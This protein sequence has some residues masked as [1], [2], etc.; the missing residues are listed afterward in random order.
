VAAIAVRAIAVAP[1]CGAQEHNGPQKLNLQIANLLPI[2]GVM[3]QFGKPGR[4]ASDVALEEIRKAAAKAG[5]QHTVT[6]RNIDY[7][8]DPPLAVKY[9]GKLQEKGTDCLTGPWGSGQAGRVGAAVAAPKRILQISPSAGDVRLG[10][11]QDR[12]YLNSVAPPDSLQATAL[13]ELMSR[14]LG[15]AKGKRVNVGAIDLPYGKA[16]AKAFKEQWTDHKGII[17]KLVTY[18]ADQTSF[19][20]QI[21]ALAQGKPDAWVFFDFVDVY[22]R[23]ALELLQDKKSGFK[24]SK[25]FGTDSLANPRL[26][27]IGPTVSDGL[28]GVAISAPNK[29]RSA[30][31]FD[32]AFKRVP[33]TNR[34]T[35][36]A[37]QFDDV[38]LCY[39]S[40]VAAGTT[41]SP[42]MKDEVRA[43]SGPPGKKY[44]WL[45]LDKAIKA[46]EAGED[47]DYEGVS[48]PINLDKH[49][50]ASAGVYDVYKVENNALQETD[51]IA[52]P[53]GGGG[54]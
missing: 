37:Q 9:A 47:I 33:G 25:V 30:D 35:F 42:E 4:R 51:Q 49:G 28:R 50:S 41:S 39:L 53:L 3:D 43:V 52:V 6:M 21:N 22:V 15:G 7:K 23:I 40:A 26:P 38:V 46:L 17:N 27:I 2:T 13:V 10:Q 24:P 16:L 29:G 36:D 45:E 34:Q 5:A 44:T 11:V 48:G 54:I 14:E 18:R 8:S 19:K 31:T 12:G 20:P 32:S 1:G